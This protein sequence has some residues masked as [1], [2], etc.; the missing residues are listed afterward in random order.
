MMRWRNCWEW[1]VNCQN[2]KM[3]LS[4]MYL[5]GLNILVCLLHTHTHTNL[6]HFI[7][8]HQKCVK[9]PSTE[10]FVRFCGVAPSNKN[11][12]CVM[13]NKMNIHKQY[14]TG[15]GKDHPSHS[16]RM[17]TVD[18]YQGKIPHRVA[19]FLIFE[20]DSYSLNNSK[21]CTRIFSAI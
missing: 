17:L 13:V 2:D 21:H 18:W 1:E 11:R 3:W 5:Q 12:I 9:C 16:E 14:E 15:C 10:D 6:F 7:P 4:K 20:L 8:G 19:D